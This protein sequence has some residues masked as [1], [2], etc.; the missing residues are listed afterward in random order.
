MSKLEFHRLDEV[1]TFY[2]VTTIFLLCESMAVTN[3][4]LEICQSKSSLTTAVKNNGPME[5]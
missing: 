5:R 2:N 3:L 4:F 1:F